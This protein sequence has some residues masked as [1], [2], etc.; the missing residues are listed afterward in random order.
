MTL[1]ALILFSHVAGAFFLF[2]GFTLEWLSVSYL[3]RNLESNQA[4]SWIH[5]ARIAPRFYGPALGV[6]LFSGGYLASK[7]GGN[8][9]WILVSF[10]TLLVIGVIG[11]VFTGPRVRTI[12][13]A[14]KE[15]TGR[16]STAF[17]N[18]LHDPVLLA[19]VRLRVALVFG[20]VLL[21]V[22]K[23]SARLSLVT[24]AAATPL[25]MI[26]ALP[27]WRRSAIQ[28]AKIGQLGVRVAPGAGGKS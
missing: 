7:M 17:Q 27:A 22:S 16:I 15:D 26:A 9:G 6:V 13:K 28:N 23:L 11:V 2:A 8:Q 4:D 10:I 12:W 3:R 25:G 14:S 24:I 20:V 21:M 19:S 1:Y 5:L 18:R